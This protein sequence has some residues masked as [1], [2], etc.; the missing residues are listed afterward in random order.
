MI[1]LLAPAGNWDSL[2]AATENGADAVYLA[3]AKFGAR[4]LAEN[5]VGDK[6]KAA[7]EYAHLRGV[8]VHVTVNTIVCDAEIP[9]LKDYLRE[10]YEYGA[11]ALLVQ[12]LGV[13][14]LA[15]EIVPD[16]PL[17]A[18]TQM[19]VTTLEGVRE[20]AAWGFSRVV[21]ARELSLRDIEEICAASPVEIEVFAHGALCVCYSGQCL[22][23]S[24][25]GARSGN[26]GRCA[27][28][29]RLPYD[30]ID[31]SGRSVIKK[32][33]EGDYYLL[34]PKDL[35]TIELLPELV[36]AGVV[37]LKIEG[38]MKRPEY[39][40]TVVRTYR[41]V[42][43]RVLS[44]ENFV[45]T[46]AEKNALAQIFNRDFTSAYL[47][48][49]RPAL[50][51]EN[52]PGRGMMSYLRPN[53]RGIFLGRVLSCDQKNRLVKMKLHAD[54]APG[55]QVDFWVKV[56]GRV[57]VTV[58]EL[59]DA[60]GKSVDAAESGATVFFVVGSPVHSH[61]R[62]FKIY[63]RRL[64]EAAKKSFSG[65]GKRKIFLAVEARAAVG[66]PLRLFGRDGDGNEATAQTEFIGE[67]AKN[68]PL[69]V[70]TL[71]KQL[72]RLGDT[73]FALESFKADV[74]ENVMVPL[75]EIN[76]ARRRLTEE[77]T[78]KRLAVGGAKQG[79]KVIVKETTILPSN[80]SVSGIVA[81]VD[82]L[83]KAEAALAGGAAAIVFGG[84]T[85]DHRLVPLSEYR[86][87]AN[88][89]ETRGRKIFW[90]TPRLVLPE[91][92]PYFAKL[93]RAL[94]ELPP[95]EIYLHNLSLI[96]LVRRH[97]PACR[98]H[99][100]YSLITANRETV[101]FW[102]AQGASGITLSPELTLAQVAHLAAQS[103]LP[104]ECIVHGRLELMVSRY[105]AAN[106]FAQEGKSGCSM[107]CVKRKLFLQDRKNM[108]FPLGFDGF[109]QMHVLNG[110]TLSM[111]PFAS[112]LVSSGVKRLRLE[113]KDC[114]AKEIAT[115]TEKYVRAQTRG[116]EE[117]LK[118]EEPP[119]ITRGHYF[120]GVW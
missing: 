108:R 67:A 20:L 80:G 7:V 29:C 88:L 92:L 102:A 98:I 39:V 114:P 35:N 30:L 3:G 103:P 49:L 60:Q 112:Q 104:L 62:A 85:Y 105:C 52:V 19:T 1:E 26:R 120:R 13:A 93:F 50:R 24:M 78:K 82:G 109:C 119:E 111:L 44:A 81:A 54:L 58:T 99:P 61:D 118:S 34:S 59:F 64:T 28:P 115:I 33:G 38:R 27:Q 101:L 10:L 94:G 97:L 23:S 107:P 37:S 47:P 66:E 72:D 43:D 40:A 87:A 83:A 100:D 63:D 55:D 110:K 17:H 12:D 117:M 25:I 70:E 53:N 84:D 95:T 6:M 5:F 91:H 31:E 51:G 65:A 76:E 90:A 14:K 73:P 8:K 74:G 96:D 75:S 4:A 9:A 32:Q 15:R 36:K 56:G 16:M 18:S 89:A 46:A 41:S 106:A 45:P 71:R 77:L 113:L 48:S 21:L 57:N 2:K 42:L 68:R 11:D 22:M 69:T 79:Q 116:D 86:A